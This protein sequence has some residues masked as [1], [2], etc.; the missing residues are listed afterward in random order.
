MYVNAEYHHDVSTWR[1]PQIPDNPLDI[2][3]A[4]IF[5]LPGQ[6]LLKVICFDLVSKQFAW[7]FAYQPSENEKLLA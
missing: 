5:C 1:K 4:L 7:A 2:Q 3:A 6:V